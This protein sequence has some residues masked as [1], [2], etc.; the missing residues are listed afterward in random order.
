MAKA[1]SGIDKFIKYLRQ[2]FAWKQD[3]N[4]PE[5]EEVYSHQ[6]VKEALLK[7]KKTDPELYRML[8]YL[9]QTKRTRNAIAE[10]LYC[11]S[12]TLRRKWII[13]LHI[14]MNYL[15]N[16]EVTEDIGPIDLIQKLEYE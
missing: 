3:F 15:V 4:C 7:L 8:S 9:W 2:D 6:Q 1:H 16:H 10:H 5:T 14:L 12:S 13:S 11:D